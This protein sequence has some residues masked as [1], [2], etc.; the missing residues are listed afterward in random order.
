MHSLEKCLENVLIFESQHDHITYS[1]HHIDIYA[2]NH[3]WLRN[4]RY[5]VLLSEMICGSDF[6]R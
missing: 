1:Q 5:L 3:R 6:V 2:P 4:T